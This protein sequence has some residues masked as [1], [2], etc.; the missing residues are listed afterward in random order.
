[1]LVIVD[2]HIVDGSGS[3]WFEGSV[4]VKDGSIADVGRLVN[5][6][7]KR[8]IDAKGLVVAPGFIDLHSHSDFTLLVD[9][10]AQSKIRQGVTTEILG[11]SSSAGPVAKELDPDLAGTGLTRDWTTLGEY[12]ARFLAVLILLAGV[13]P[14][15][16]QQGITLLTSDDLA[17]DWKI[18]KQ[19][20][21]AVADRMPAGLYDFKPNPTEMTF[22]EQLVHIAAVNYYWLSRLTETKNEFIKPTQTDKDSTM[23]LLDKS[24]DYVIDTLPKITQQQLDRMITGVGW[25]SRDEVNGRGILLNLLV[26][27]AHHRAQCE[28]YMRVK[29]IAPPR[30]RF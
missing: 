16:G 28:V 14:A 1:M 4:A 7:A 2:G 9:G 8:V 26:H 11:E 5:A 23:R 20:T 24:F 25:A 6:T 15:Y 30:Y 19:Y 17:T 22:A 10:R 27:T 18:S 21:L 12:F 29:N 13:A 3:P